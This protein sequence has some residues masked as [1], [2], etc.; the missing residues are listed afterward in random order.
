MMQAVAKYT[1]HLLYDI[2]PATK[3]EFGYETVYTDDPKEM[4][5]ILGNEGAWVSEPGPID[6]TQLKLALAAPAIN[7]LWGKEKVFVAKISNAGNILGVNPCETDEIFGP[8]M[9]HCD[10]DGTM[11]VVRKWQERAFP[12]RE[13]TANTDVPGWKVRHRKISHY[14]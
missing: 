12:D 14:L 1:K 4:V 3:D 8:D 7:A 13:S 6:G 5:A 9:K 2:P 10:S 11:Y